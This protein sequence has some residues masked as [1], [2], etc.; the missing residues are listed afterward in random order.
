MALFPVRRCP[1]SRHWRSHTQPLNTFR[2]VLFLHDISTCTW[3][4]VGGRDHC[5]QLTPLGCIVV[6]CSCLQDTAVSYWGASNPPF[7]FLSSLLFLP[8]LPLPP[9]FSPPVP[10]SLSF[11]LS[12]SIFM[13]LCRDRIPPNASGSKCPLTGL[14]GLRPPV[15]SRLR[16]RDSHGHFLNDNVLSPTLGSVR[17]PITIWWSRCPA[18]VSQD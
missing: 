16:R 4:L 15:Y 14:A 17:V 3:A 8:R 13:Y 6:H 9:L 18:R 5:P 11:S 7:P 1:P 2:Y 10:L 12:S